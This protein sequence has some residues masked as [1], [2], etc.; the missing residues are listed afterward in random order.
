VRFRRHGRHDAPDHLVVEGD[1][2]VRAVRVWS[3]GCAVQPHVGDIRRVQAEA[4]K[5]GR[6]VEGV[7]DTTELDHCRH[8]LEA[9]TA[10]GQTREVVQRGDL[11]RVVREHRGP[12]V[13]EPAHVRTC[14]RAV[15]EP[16]DA[17]NDAIEVGGE[18]NRSEVT[19]IFDRAAVGAHPAETLQLDFERA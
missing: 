8:E 3:W 15:V 19:A 2:D 10:I 14:Q 18:T 17:F 12:A 5:R 1:L 13:V 11:R 9:R 16:V 4:R 7:D 6:K